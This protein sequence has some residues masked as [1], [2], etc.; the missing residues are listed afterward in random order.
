MSIVAPQ[1]ALLQL[2]LAGAVH[3]GA[4]T[5]GLVSVPAARFGHCSFV[6]DGTMYA[7]GGTTIA[8]GLTADF[9]A[10]HVDGGRW[11]SAPAATGNP[12]PAIEGHTCTVMGVAVLIT[13]GTLA[14]GRTNRTFSLIFAPPGSDTAAAAWSDG[15]PLP[16]P[17]RR[18]TAV[19]VDS[20]N[21]GRLLVTC[22]C[23]VAD[24]SSRLA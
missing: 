19:V 14:S 18:H 1:R 10:F 20:L 23:T 13:G 6:V 16:Q 4:E 5:A 17:V 21:G 22:E 8:G 12:P 15:P 2:M 9:L 7:L 24:S 11:V 3:A